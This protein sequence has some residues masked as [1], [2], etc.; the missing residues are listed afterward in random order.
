MNETLKTI[1][2]LATTHGYFTDRPVS[3]EDLET[4]VQASLRAANASA[5]QS[6][7]LVVVEDRQ[8]IRQLC[9][10]N[11]AVGIVYCVDYNRILDTAAFLGETYEVNGFMDFITGSTDTILAAQTGAIAARSLGLDMLFTNGIHRGDVQ[12]VFN[13]LNLPEKYCIPLI[14]LVL[15]YGEHTKAPR[16]RLDGAGVV[17]RGKYDHVSPARAEEIVALYDE[18]ENMLGLEDYWANN[19]Y[20]HYLGW[21][22]NDWTHTDPKRAEIF[23]NLLKQRG[24]LS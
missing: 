19:G 5:R 12:R 23:E 22:L 2:N 20:E 21:F 8:V 18:R 1:H 10:Y 3:A 13:M 6:Y 4:I 9:G 16:G 14:M 24:F 17:H 11:G 7:S 15:G